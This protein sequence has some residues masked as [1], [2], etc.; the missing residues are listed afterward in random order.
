[1]NKLKDSEI[2]QQ[3]FR[4]HAFNK[5]KDIKEFLGR[6]YGGLE[7][8]IFDVEGSIHID[9]KVFAVMEEFEMEKKNVLCASKAWT[10][11]GK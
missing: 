1:M 4:L 3:W 8:V 7:I 11:V 10:D 6:W 2:P 9:S 5:S